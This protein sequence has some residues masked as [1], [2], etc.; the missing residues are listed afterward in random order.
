MRSNIMNHIEY[1]EFT[2]YKL[3]CGYCKFTWNSMSL[4]DSAQCPSCGNKQIP[5]SAG[6]ARAFIKERKQNE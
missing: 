3:Y 1:K 6:D 4:P 2:A 5:Y